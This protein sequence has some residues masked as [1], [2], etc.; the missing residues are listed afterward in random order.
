MA[1]RDGVGK[2]SLPGA[3]ERGGRTLSRQK[4]S[5]LCF[6]QAVR[7][8]LA[9]NSWPALTSQSSGVCFPFSSSLST[10]SP[11]PATSLPQLCL[12]VPLPGQEPPKGTGFPAAPP[13]P[14]V[15]ETYH[16]LSSW[17]H[18]HPLLPIEGPAVAGHFPSVGG[19]GKE[20]Y[21]CS[22]ERQEIPVLCKQNCRNFSISKVFNGLL[23]SANFARL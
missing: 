9:A 17:A 4:G 16:K 21:S 11:S 1:E 18:A 15:H 12:L 7:V 3:Q 8:H 2:A 23:C 6:K 14:Y 22:G 20:A 13:G 5:M 10:S 19:K